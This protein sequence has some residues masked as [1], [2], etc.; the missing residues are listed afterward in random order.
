MTPKQNTE[1]IASAR[2][3]LSKVGLRMTGARMAVMRWLQDAKSPATHAEIAEDLVP[4][5]FDKA[6]VYRNLTDLA[7]AGLVT[8]SELGDHVSVS[9]T[10]LRAHET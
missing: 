6:T 4:L 3:L 2:T 1:A 9:Y 7:E 5:G 8:R 10:H